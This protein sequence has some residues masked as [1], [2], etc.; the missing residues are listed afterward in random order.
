MGSK[1]RSGKYVVRTRLIN[2]SDVAIIFRLEPWGEQF[3]MP[4]SGQA[5]TDR[6]AEASRD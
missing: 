1:K 3:E 2:S 4:P 5:A 6:L